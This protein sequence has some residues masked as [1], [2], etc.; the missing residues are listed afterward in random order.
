MAETFVCRL[1]SAKGTISG[2]SKEDHIFSVQTGDF[3]HFE[4]E[5]RSPFASEET[6]LVVIEN[7]S[8]PVNHRLTSKN[9]VFCFKYQ[10]KISG[11]LCVQLKKG[12][13]VSDKSF[14]VVNPLLSFSGQ[15]IKPESLSM[16]TLLSRSLGHVDN[17]IR[18]IRDQVSIGY[19]FFHLTPIQ[20][21]GGSRSLYCIKD[22]TRLSSDLFSGLSH[23][24]AFDKLT[25][26][27]QE[28][29]KLGAG[30]MIDVVLNHTA[31]DS[32]FVEDHPEA[33]YN[34]S[35]S[36]YLRAAYELDEALHNFTVAV[37]K[38][39]IQGL[40]NRN[41]IENQ[42]DL[43]TI[44]NILKVEWLPRYKF[45]QYFQMDVGKVLKNFESGTEMTE[46]NNKQIEQLKTK[47]LEFFI[48]TNAL[49]GEGEGLLSTEIDYKLVR[50]ACQVLGHSFENGVKEI[51]KILPMINSYLLNRYDKHFAE[52]L[53][54]IEG[55][56][57]YHKIEKGDVEITPS[58]PVVGRYFQHLRNGEVVLHNGFIMG[59]SD[60]LKDFAGKENWHYF[61]RNVVIWADNIKL[62][63]GRSPEDCPALWETMKTYVVQMARS[64]KAIRLDNAHGTPLEV[65]AFMLRAAR[66][67]N[68][69]LY[70]MAEL[71]TSDSKL[72]A[73]FVNFLGINALVREAMNAPDPGCLGGIVYG[74]GNGERKSLGKI[75]DL[76]FCNDSLLVDFEMKGIRSA[77]VPAI[78]YDCTHDNPTPVERRKAHDALPS[79]AIVAM[80]NCFVAS[81]RGYDEFIP[82]QLSVIT[83][84][85][86]YPLYEPSPIPRKY[87][88]GG[89]IEI[90][91]TFSIEETQKVQKVQVKGEWD[92]WS[93]FYDL[94]RLSETNFELTLQVSHELL[95]RELSYKF[96]IDGTSWVHDWKQ[97]H[98]KYGSNLNNYLKVTH[99]LKRTGVFPNMRAARSYLNTLHSKMSEEGFDEIYIHKC[100]N[101]LHLIIRQQPMT[102]DSYVL[103]V[104]SAFWDDPNPS[105]QYDLR[106]PGI[107]KD[108]EFISVLS[109]KTWGFIKDPQVVNGLK[110]HLEILSNLEI[111]GNVTRDNSQN[112]DVLNLTKIPQAFVMVLKTELFSKGSLQYLNNIYDLLSSPK[113][114][115]FA[116]LNLEQLNHLLWR[117]GKEELDISGQ[118]RDVYVVNSNR[119]KYAGFGG[120]VIEFKKLLK[121]NN[122]LAH[123]ICEN[124]RRGDWLLD[125]SQ[126]RLQSMI[127]EVQFNFISSAIQK[128]K[129]LPRS[130]IPKHF[131]KFVLLVFESSTRYQNSTLFQRNPGTSLERFLLTSVSQFWGWV[132]SASSQRLRASMS[133]GLPHFTTE[134]TRVWGRDTFIAF[135]GLLLLTRQFAEAKSLILAFAS[136]LRHGLIPNLLDSCNNPRYNAR[137]AT[138]F[139]MQGLKQYIKLAP[140]GHL[141]LQESVSMVFPSD[142]QSDSRTGEVI[143]TIEVIIQ[144][145][146]QKHASGIEFREWNAGTRIDAHMRDEGFNVKIGLDPNTGLVYGGNRWNCGTWMDKMGSSSKAGNAGVPATPRD[147]SA[148]EIVA[149]VY[150]TLNFLIKLH[151]KGLF[152]YSGVTLKDGNVLLYTTWAD[153]LKKHFD[154][155]F[156]IPESSD[157]LS[158]YF[159]DTLGSSISK[160]DFQ[161]RPNQCIA[162]AIAPRLFDVNH[163]QTALNTIHR[164]LM[165]GFVGSQIGIKTLADSD[166]AYR[167]FYDNENDSTDISVA[168]GFSY[169][170]GP[171]WVW[172]VG[173]FLMAQLR[174]WKNL[175]IVDK[176]LAAHLSYFERSDWMSLPELTNSFGEYCPFSCESQAWS[177]GTLIEV[178]DRVRKIR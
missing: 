139:F 177:V 39:E 36:P 2:L 84:T 150:S 137:D 66:E 158:G 106:L 140:E 91:I 144:E 24:Q 135:K 46:L 87:D 123:D 138:W 49:V 165:A 16:V 79:A 107:I 148:I 119:F 21:L 89:D 55:D 168:H 125:Y 143:K 11:S 67:A 142:S 65:S 126:A 77:P 20:V 18:V 127:P 42:K 10:V 154:R 134:Y 50:K 111:F 162:L 178:V 157:R 19:N 54:N 62:R 47:G 99:S 57:R 115:I 95:N 32:D 173:Y 5:P 174:F 129:Q 17:W 82:Q 74:F 68:P 97:P 176:C 29:E 3:L 60:V 13:I 9:G 59:Y 167:G 128:I 175:D 37:I 76:G 170:N 40:R 83:E 121:A 164:E 101:D 132:P 43:T 4:I 12:E 1:D 169:H 45:H 92:N 108:V 61:R 30:C 94:T 116:G 44:M 28:T 104:R 153:N 152:R 90:L 33:T 14:V 26:V 96:I 172:P 34:L 69:D 56:I 27:M 85:R 23:D 48:R 35:N 147:G 25:Q 31:F 117:S 114:E 70:V 113:Q 141:I 103:I 52:I 171:E 53:V 124:L 105:S 86:T 71:F 110:G 118:K 130:L 120:L 64:F 15:K 163:A 41:R 58:N 156:F 100:S 155:L 98:K 131:I 81:V 122:P 7:S 88:L 22:P 73:Y 166:P 8:E 112:I 149:M 145:I 102:G 146:M 133:A 93:Q 151:S 136:V 109:F 38:K 75:D 80:A 161:L 51:K 63:Y 72:D 6:E 78:L 159:K 160:N